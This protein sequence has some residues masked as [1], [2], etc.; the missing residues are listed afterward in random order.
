M[1]YASVSEV[2]E[3]LAGVFNPGAAEGLDAVFQFDITGEG[4][5]S[6]YIT[7]ENGA[8]QVSPGTHDAASVTL[9]MSSDTW[10][11]MVNQEIDGMQA[12]MTG[13]L[14]ADGDLLLAQRITQLFSL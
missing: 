12:F 6:W 13:Q 11:G 4:G 8:C 2:F 3:K 14:Q 5:G 7:I 10:L 1:P 9:T